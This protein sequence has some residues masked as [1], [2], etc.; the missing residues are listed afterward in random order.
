MNTRIAIIAFLV[1]IGGCASKPLYAQSSKYPLELEFDFNLSKEARQ[2]FLNYPNLRKDL[3]DVYQSWR[4]FKCFGDKDL[5]TCLK[6]SAPDIAG[7][8]DDIYVATPDL[9]NDK[10][11]DLMLIYGPNTGLA[12]GSMCG[13]TGVD[14]YEFRDGDYYNIGAKGI[15]RYTD[16]ALGPPKSPGKFRDIIEKYSLD[17]CADYEHYVITIKFDEKNHTYYREPAN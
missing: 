6:E 8:F 14:F 5:E 15:L 16:F 17:Y 11:R 10:H 2:K 13:T 1:A 4:E 9:N 12:G 3:D 7:I